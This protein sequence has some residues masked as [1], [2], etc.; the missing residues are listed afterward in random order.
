MRMV[1][2]NRVAILFRISL[3]DLRKKWNRTGERIIYSDSAFFCQ[4][5][6]IA[7]SNLIQCTDNDMF[8]FSVEAPFCTLKI[9]DALTVKGRSNGIT[10]ILYREDIKGTYM[11]NIT[12]PLI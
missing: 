10:D 4:G 1:I 9:V 11:A 5:I 3:Y 12:L 6:Q 2:A 8:S 7:G